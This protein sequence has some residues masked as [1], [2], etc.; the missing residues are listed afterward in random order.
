MHVYM[1]FLAKICVAK[2]SQR[3]PP[4]IQHVN[5]QI[6]H[7]T[8]GIITCMPFPCVV[9]GPRPARGHHWVAETGAV[10]PPPV[11]DEGRRGQQVSAI[12]SQMR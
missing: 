4:Q 6:Q 10:R 7:V 2:M 5:D 12:G 11:R 8:L 9:V 3:G 1:L